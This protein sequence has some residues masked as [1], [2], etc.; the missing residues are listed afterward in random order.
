MVFS[1]KDKSGSLFGV[2]GVGTQTIRASH[3]LTSEKFVVAR[4]RLDETASAIAADH[5]RT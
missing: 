3:L 2:R 5:D 1:T 4:K